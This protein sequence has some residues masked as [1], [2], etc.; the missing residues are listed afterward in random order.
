MGTNVGDALSRG[1]TVGLRSA[2]GP[3]LLAVMLSQGLVALDSTILA[4]SI[5]SIVADL[6]GFA[7]FPWLFSIYMLAQVACVPITSK[8]GDM[9]GRKPVILVGIGLFLLGSILCGLAWDMSSLIAFRAIQGLGA[10][11]I[12]PMA[13]TIVGDIYTVAE[14]ARVQ[15]YLASVWALSSVLGPTVGGLFSQFLSWRWI[16][17]VNI[18][19][20]LIA[21]WRLIGRYHEGIERRRHRV[22]YAGAITLTVG[23][24]ALILWLL[25]GGNG[26]AWVSTP[27][28]IVLGVGIF[29]LTAFFVIEPRVPEPILDLRLITR[30]M[31]ASTTLVAM[32]VGAL[33]TG[34]SSFA[35]TYLQN[36]IGVTPIV[37]GLAL[38]ALT[39]GWPIAS[40]LSG[41]LYMRWG[42]RTTALLGSSI[43][44]VGVVM[45]ALVTPWP[46][47][48]TVAAV[49]FVIGFGLGWTA[50]PTLIAAQA[51]VSWEERGATTG[52]NVLARSVGG[53]VGVA[54]FGAIANSVIASG[55]G[56]HDFAT[57]VSASQGVFIAAAVA[58]VLIIVWVLTMPRRES[59]ALVAG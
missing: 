46:H 51:S 50:A 9:V 13:T 7:Q 52:V 39:I 44:A 35:P 37:A 49:S 18:P 6:G 32:C 34:L 2:R 54:V 8:L 55:A 56:E 10:G 45:L 17:F 16:F 5:P 21:A 24:T 15:G 4:T 25:E 11:A 53:S 26:W 30:P 43:C 58:A 27:S 19:L 1:R 20:C 47:P 28:F 41:H 33:M 29:A 42:F 48:V 12:Q 3:V 40:T 38:A 23:L 59:T 57:I 14:R 31:I 22:D 36:S